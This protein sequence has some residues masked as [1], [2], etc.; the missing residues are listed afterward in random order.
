MRD[1]FIINGRFLSQKLTGVHRYAYEMSCALHKLGCKFL[2]IAPQNILKDYDCPF[3]V[4][5]IGKATSHIWEQIEL[6]IYLHKHYK[7]EL[8]VN[9]SGLGCI[10]H[11]NNICTIHDISYLENPSWFSKSYYY[12]Y[13][14]ST[15]IIAKR[16]IKILTVSEF[17][18]NELINKI[19]VS[20]QKIEVIYNAVAERVIH[21][22]KYPKKNKENYILTVSSLDPRKN[23]QRLIEAFNSLK[24]DNCKL[25]IIGK[26][27][28]VFKSQKYEDYNNPN[29]IFTGYLSDS[30]LATYYN[31]ATAFIY[32]SLYEGFGIPNLEAM[33]NN[34]P[35]LTS[36][37]PPHVEVCEDA[38]LY[39]D[40]YNTKV[41]AEKISEIINNHELRENMILAGKK[42]SAK[43]SWI[44]SAQKLSEVIKEL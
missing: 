29:I 30:E 27:D 16:A 3:E 34:C 21:T 35:V 1:F 12:L 8:L 44:S 36:N 4:I 39:F 43:F 17:S 14:F 33:M 26:K 13:K 2:V 7:K 24:Y 6:P 20:S 5:T 28:R 15:P 32:P 10:F 37:I 9:F 22:N 31:N 25:Y 42:R 18:K 19:G 23:F 40:P 38:A 41:M 11:K